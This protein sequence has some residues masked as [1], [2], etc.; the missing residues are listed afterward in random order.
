V[1]SCYLTQYKRNPIEIMI[2]QKPQV[3]TMFTKQHGAGD[4]MK[5]ITTAII[6]LYISLLCSLSYATDQ[7]MLVLKSLE[8]IRATLETFGKYKELD[9]LLDDSKAEINILKR[10]CNNECFLSAVETCYLSYKKALDQ[11]W[12]VKNVPDYVDHY[13][14]MAGEFEKLQLH[15]TTP[16]Y[17]DKIAECKREAESLMQKFKIAAKE[18]PFT[19][20]NA[21]SNLDK[22]YECLKK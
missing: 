4:P 14:T 18:L 22:A 1:S 8:K 21:N 11:T 3:L 12:T 20:K 19:I 15:Y 5:P 16:K 17:E 6:L 13:I 9:P 7:E 10:V 2:S